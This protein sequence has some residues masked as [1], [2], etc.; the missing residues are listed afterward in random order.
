MPLA[1]LK[2]TAAVSAQPPT[3]RIQPVAGSRRDSRVETTSAMPATSANPSSQPA[4]PPSAVV[5]QPQH[6]RVAAEQAVAAEAAT[7][8]APA[9][10]HALGPPAWPSS[11]PRP[12]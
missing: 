9:A 10:R 8:A 6:A 12:L 5:E 4:C 11:R 2:A 3:A 7:A 1:L